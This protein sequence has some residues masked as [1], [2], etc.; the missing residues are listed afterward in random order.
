MVMAYVSLALPATPNTSAVMPSRP[1]I[2]VLLAPLAVISIWLWWQVVT[3]ITNL[4]KAA[5][6][7]AP[8]DSVQEV[9]Q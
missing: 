6:P 8:T 1:V 3:L 5:G 9:I 4:Q 2:D 7:A